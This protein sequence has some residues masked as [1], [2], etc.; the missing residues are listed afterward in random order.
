M[1]R[2]RKIIQ[3][4]VAS[5]INPE[6]FP[7]FKEYVGKPI[8]SVPSNILI[9]WLGK[10]GHEYVHQKRVILIKQE[11]VKRKDVPNITT[12]N[13][14][15]FTPEELT[16]F[17][18]VFIN[19]RNQTFSKETEALV[20]TVINN[21]DKIN[22]KLEIHFGEYAGQPISDIPHDYLEAW[23][24]RYF[25]KSTP[26]AKQALL[27]SPDTFFLN[28]KF[29]LY[30]TAKNLL[31]TTPRRMVGMSKHMGQV[32]DKIRIVMSVERKAFDQKNNQHMIIGKVKFNNIVGM[33]KSI[34][35]NEIQVGEK[36]IFSGNIVKHSVFR[37]E[38]YT[39]LE[40]TGLE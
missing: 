27:Q 9:P 36:I 17:F 26:D 31:K 13:Y 5:A 25:N 30:F 39:L 21:L 1:E 33:T 16:L 6:A 20:D 18:N 14:T 28:Q 24:K 11:L 23:I 40:I 29:R 2:I 7:H 37:D 3:E 12:S 15:K 34:W 4:V 10:H 8:S 22:D 38:E 35:G 32:G 19:K